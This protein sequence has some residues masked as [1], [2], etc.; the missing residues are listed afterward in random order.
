MRLI[1]TSTLIIPR[2]CHILAIKMTHAN[3]RKLL[4]QSIV[5]HNGRK[6]TAEQREKPVRIQW[7]PERNPWLDILPYRSIQIGIG[8]EISRKWAE[9]WVDAI[10]DVTEMASDLKRLLDEKTEVE[11]GDLIKMSLMPSEREY[12]VGEELRE[13][14]EMD[15]EYIPWENRAMLHMDC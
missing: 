5:V 10:E 4:S 9:Q 13:I 7:D 6:L 15:G 3:F 11:V 1:L 12:D 14:L 2:Q 8:P